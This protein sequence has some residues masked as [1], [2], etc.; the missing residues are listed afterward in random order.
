MKKKK[1]KIDQKGQGKKGLNWTWGIR[2][3]CDIKGGKARKGGGKI[4]RPGKNGNHLKTGGEK[5][6]YRG[7][8]KKKK[9][10]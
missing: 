2:R 3:Q 1:S 5:A 10:K 6:E 4:L 7:K 9:I 8:Y